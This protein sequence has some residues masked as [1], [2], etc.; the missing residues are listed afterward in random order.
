M[1]TCLERGAVRMRMIDQSLTR[2]LRPTLRAASMFLA[3]RVAASA[4]ERLYVRA[5][6][7][8][9]GE[10]PLQSMAYTVDIVVVVA[11]PAAEDAA[12]DDDE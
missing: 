8:L 7:L 6:V 10:N 3:Q 11:V 5:R 12:A 2:S 4:P 9:T 1:C